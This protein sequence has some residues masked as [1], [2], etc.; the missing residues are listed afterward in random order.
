M[1]ALFC[2]VGL[3]FF[4]GFGIVVKYDTPRH[5]KRLL[6]S[7][8]ISTS[9]GR[10]CRQFCAYLRLHF[11]AKIFDA[12]F[13]CVIS[14]HAFPASSALGR[15]VGAASSSIGGMDPLGQFQIRTPVGVVYFTQ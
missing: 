2:L 9:G 13:H 5:A 10:E 6:W 1:E 15:M 7:L 11:G 3:A 4:H 8:T 14:P 12:E